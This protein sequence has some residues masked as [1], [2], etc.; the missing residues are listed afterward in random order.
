MHN[1]AIDWEQV[2]SRVAE[3]AA[4]LAGEFSPGPAERERI[5]H[6]RAQL[7]AREPEP[8]PDGERL[9]IV[10]FLI[11]GECYG[12]ES[13]YVRE[14]HTLKDCTPV[15][16]A[17]R[18]VLGLINVRGRIIPVI[19]LRKLFDLQDKG[20]SDLAKAVIIRGKGLEFGILA[21]AV[22]GVGAIDEHA[23][24][25]S[26]PVLSGIREEFL[27]GVTSGRMI[28]LDA[29]KLLAHDKLIVNAEV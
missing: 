2:R 12:I 3:A 1:G 9:E 4:A 15:P 10:V 14:V 5:L 25:K 26:L 24:Q 7:L 6:E 18:F 8:L 20:L 16:C 13:R 11:S 22:T 23:L 17:P 28:I 19:D 21:D 29:E 27:K